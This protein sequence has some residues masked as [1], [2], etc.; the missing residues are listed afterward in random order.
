MVACARSELGQVPLVGHG[1]EMWSLNQAGRVNRN[2]I[3]FIM[4]KITLELGRGKPFEG[5]YIVAAS[6]I[7]GFTKAYFQSIDEYEC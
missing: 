1:D 4:Y 7:T 2:D 6:L 3:I 5:L